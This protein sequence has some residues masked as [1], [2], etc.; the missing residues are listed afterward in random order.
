M[1]YILS[2]MLSLTAL[3]SWGQCNI[4]FNVY[5]SYGDGWNSEVQGFLVLENV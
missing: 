3:L 1:K 5:D 4:Y 2:L